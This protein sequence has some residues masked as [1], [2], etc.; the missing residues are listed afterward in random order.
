MHREKIS[1][2]TLL[3]CEDPEDRLAVL[4]PLSHLG[5]PK[6]GSCRDNDGN[7]VICWTRALE[8]VEE[9]IIRCDV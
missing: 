8:R 6:G 4:L 1:I 5:C 7:C 9:V 2:W 3:D